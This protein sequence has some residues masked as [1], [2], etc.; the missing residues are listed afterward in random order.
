MRLLTERAR[1]ARSPGPRHPP[2]GRHAARCP[3]PRARAPR[4][5]RVPRAEA[6]LFAADKAQHVD[7]LI[8]PALAEGKVV[9]T[10]RYVDSSITYQGAGRELG[11][12]EITELQHWAVGGLLPD[13]T[14]VLDVAPEVGR[15]RR[16]DVHDRLESEADAFHAAVRRATSSSP[17]GTRNATSCSTQRVPSSTSTPPSPRRSGASTPRHP[18]GRSAVT[19]WHD[20]VGQEPTI[21][22]LSRA[23][24]DDTSMTH[25]WLFTGPPGSGRSTAARAFAA[26]LQCPQGGCGRCASAAPRSTAPMPTSRSSRPRGSR[27][28][29]PKPAPSCRRPRCGRR[30]V[31]GGSSSSRT[32][33]VSRPTPTPRPTR[34]SRPSRS[35]P[36]APCGCCARRASRTSSSPSAPGRGTC[37][38]ARLRSRLSPTCSSAATASTRPWRC[39]RPARP[40]PTSVWPD[41]SLATNRPASAGV[42]SSPWRP[43]SSAWVMP[44]VPRQTWRRS[45]TRSRAPRRRARRRRAGEAHRDPRRRPVRPHPAPPHP[46]AG[47]RARAGA[48]D[49]R[50]PSRP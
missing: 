25:A 15:E 7:Q 14:I 29:S 11:A 1:A 3:D 17:H 31:A 30:W 19:V 43:R 28:R 37:G 6:L 36:R 4:G 41:V 16:G 49:P 22:T 50:D 26:A 8:R 13:L 45:P 32:P 47:R 2:A 46:L 12:G 34:S 23:V 42:T 35:P 40:S 38:C 5:P 18:P 20:L 33:T 21:E 24:S 9:I 48:E 10:D 44:S 27:S 39:T